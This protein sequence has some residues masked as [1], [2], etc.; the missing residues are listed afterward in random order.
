MRQNLLLIHGNGGANARFQLMLEY[1]RTQSPEL[2][3]HL[4]LLPGF[5]GRPLPPSQ[6]VWALFI[7]ALGRVVATAPDEQW[8]L[9]GHGIGGSMLLEWAA[10]D[11]ILP[12]GKTFQPDQIIMHSI[13]GASLQ[14]RWFPK[15]MKL[16][17]MR[18]FIHWLIYQP[19]LRPR[20]EKRL[21]LEPQNIPAALR[22]RFFEDYRACAAFEVL[23]DLITPRWY[24][25]VQA[26]THKEPFYF[27]WGGQ[28]RVVAANFLDFWRNDYPAAQFEV[29]E[30]WDHFPMLETPKAFYHKL[31]DIIQ[32]HE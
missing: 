22:T 17:P 32:T 2:R 11:W 30:D 26:K 5:E 23:F 31:M 18:R 28:E 20:W 6:D 10:R 3:M 25:K 7:E 4:P 12:N 9:Y 8:I 16:Y 29:V 19:A 13:I 14:A 27:L 15:L 24:K 1:A 21:F